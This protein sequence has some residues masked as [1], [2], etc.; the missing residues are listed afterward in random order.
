MEI[1]IGLPNTIPGTPG[2]LL[3]DW[4]RR[5][6]ERGFYGL[7]TLDRIV[8]PNYDSLTALAAVAGATSRIRMVTNILLAPVYSPVIL[9]KA[10]ASIDQIS[11]GRFTLGVGVG[12]R[13]DDF[14]VTGRDFHTR[15]RDFDAGLDVLYRVWRGEPVGG[16]ELAVS[17]TPVGDSRVPLL[18][19]GTGEHTLQ[20]LRE[21]GDGWTSGGAPPEQ[22]APFADQ[23]RATW[24]DAGR[25]GTPRIAALNYYSLGDEV[26]DASRGYLRHYYGGFLGDYAEVIAEGALRSPDA[27][28]D[29]VKQFEDAGFTEVYL[30]PTVASLDQI[31]RLADVVF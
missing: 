26:A 8:Y 2:R 12:G 29:V 17:P 6:E 27:I 3:V 13:P 5:A 25:T 19:G 20:R 11:G 31:D 22:A 15:G 21:Y 4:A 9:A 18:I 24:Q 7:A 14:A 28:R 23:V 16:G 30:D 1:G 10:A